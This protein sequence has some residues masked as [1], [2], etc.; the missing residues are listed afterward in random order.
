MKVKALLQRSVSPKP[1]AAYR[2]LKGLFEAQVTQTPAAPALRMG[3]ETLTYAALN[4]RANALAEL[5]KEQY[6]LGPA[7]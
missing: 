7:R 2:S 4:G 3:S 5:L 6:D 1:A